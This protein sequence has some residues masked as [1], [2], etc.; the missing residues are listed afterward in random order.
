MPSN[1]STHVHAHLV[2]ALLAFVV[3][4]L[5][6]FSMMVAPMDLAAAL[7]VGAVAFD[8]SGA[9]VLMKFVAVPIAILLRLVLVLLLVIILHLTKI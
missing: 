2:W 8:I 6:L 4:G 9:E 1:R 5:G 3:G 7:G